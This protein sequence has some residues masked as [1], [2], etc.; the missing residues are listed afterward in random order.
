MQ[1]ILLFVLLG[2]FQLSSAHMMLSYPVPFRAPAN[3][4]STQNSIDYS[5]TSP[6]GSAVST[7]ANSFPC[8]GYQSDFSDLSG[9][10]TSVATFARGATS[11]FTVEGGATHGGGSCQV[12][13][14]YSAT[15]TSASDYIVIKS[16]EGSCPLSDG[17]S[18]DF[19]GTSP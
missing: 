15:A 19:T 9:V 3:K 1:T 5:Y 14:A 12:S 17:E 16:F 4:H 8:K 2:G 18:F 10:G 11:N 13:L 7:A 6:L